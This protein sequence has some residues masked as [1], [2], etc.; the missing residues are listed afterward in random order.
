MGYH[1]RASSVVVSGTPIRR[2]S[3]QMRPDQSKIFKVTSIVLCYYNFFLVTQ[4]KPLF[5]MFLLQIHLKDNCSDVLGIAGLTMD[6]F[7]SERNQCNR[8]RDISF[9]IPCIFYPCQN[10]ALHYPQVY[11][12]AKLRE[13]PALSR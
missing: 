5:I 12:Q 10:V 13:E 3:G 9:V 2:P 7:K 11:G 6:H 8:S 1:G 4:F